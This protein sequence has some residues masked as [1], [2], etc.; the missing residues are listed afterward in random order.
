MNGVTVSLYRYT[1]LIE[2]EI[3]LIQYK[4]AITQL[5][6]LD[7]MISTDRLVKLINTIEAEEVIGSE[8]PE[9]V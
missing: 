1:E 8:P 9:E 7:T 4:N 6:K 3:K 2:S 5:A